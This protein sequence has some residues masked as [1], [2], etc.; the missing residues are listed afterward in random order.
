MIICYRSRVALELAN[1]LLVQERIL[2]S[3]GVWPRSFPSSQ[4]EKRSD[5]FAHQTRFL[6]RMALRTEAG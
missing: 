5:T 3:L 6:P 4:F 2:A 1:Y